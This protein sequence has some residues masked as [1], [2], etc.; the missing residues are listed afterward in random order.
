MKKFLF[1]ILFVIIVN[2]YLLFSF[3]Y[4]ID[5][6]YGIKPTKT[7]QE[8]SQS[9]QILFEEYRTKYF[10][11]SGTPQFGMWRVKV[12]GQYGDDGSYYPN[13]TV[14]EA[15]GYGM[16]IAVLMDN[17]Q[18]NTKDLYDG[19][20]KYYKY[21]ANHN[22]VM[23]WIIDENGIPRSNSAA[24][25]GDIDAAMSLIIAHYRWGSNGEINYAQEAKNLLSNILNSMVDTYDILKP[26]DSWGGVSITRPSDYITGF[27]KIFYY[28]TGENRWLKVVDNCYSTLNYFYQTYTTG[29]IADFC[30]ADGTE[31]NMVIENTLSQNPPTDY[32]Y[33]Y[34]ACRVP[35]R[36]GYDWL[37]FGDERSYRILNKIST[38]LKSKTNNN[39]SAIKDGYSLNGEALTSWQ[40]PAFVAPF[41]VAATSKVEH[42]QWL[43]DIYNWLVNKPSYGYYADSIRLLSLLL[44]TGNFPNF[45]LSK[46]GVYFLNLSNGKK[47]SGIYDIEVG[48]VGISTDG[49]KIEFFINDTMKFVDYNFPY[50]WRLDT[51]DYEDGEYNFK[52]KAYSNNQLFDE[53]Q[54]TFYIKNIK[55]SYLYVDNNPFIISRHK[56][57]RFYNVPKGKFLTIINILGEIVSSFVSENGIVE[58]DGK[59]KSGKYVESG[60][61]L[62]KIED[63][64]KKLAVI[65]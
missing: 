36:L 35:W 47:I 12:Q 3:P 45:V 33:G 26:G 22:G 55:Y 17:L 28:F 1:F 25:D 60:I 51:S 19:L 30:K 48:V 20:F 40:S 57:C 4:N 9:I 11:Q 43:D 53:K 29:L 23:K 14:S 37:W 61:Y 32:V 13:C 54:M 21:Y 49:V 59:D 65:R 62:Y 31:A 2:R 38:W 10:T 15:Q 27:F 18:N 58:W 5:Y 46:P 50:I 52:I 6:P 44:I 39:V 56:I 42:Q 63:E 7:P 41:G 16:L 34:N 8:M 64:I 24:T